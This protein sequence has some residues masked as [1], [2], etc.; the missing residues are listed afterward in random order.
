MRYLTLAEVLDLH[1]RV[2]T[3]GGGSAAVPDLGGLISGVAQPRV[4]FE[5]RD[6]HPTI[7]NQAAA[8]CISNHPWSAPQFD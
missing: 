4:T 5:G 6:L 1:R 2:M 3:Q 7:A 8:L